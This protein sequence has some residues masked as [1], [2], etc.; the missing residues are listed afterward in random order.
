[1]PTQE[2]TMPATATRMLLQRGQVSRLSGTPGT[3]LASAAGALWITVD[4][5]PRDIVLETGQAYTPRSPEGITV[6]A[7]RGPAVLD[8]Q[9]A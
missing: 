7:L 6:S 2:P 8:I 1:M 4:H 9:T 3:R 5:D